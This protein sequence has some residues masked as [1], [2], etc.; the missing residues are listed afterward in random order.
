MLVSVIQRKQKIIKGE[1]LN[2][3]LCTQFY[4]EKFLDYHTKSKKHEDEILYFF[5]I[6][7]ISVYINKDDI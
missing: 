3:L 5:L 6:F 2:L 7:I 4:W 1:Y